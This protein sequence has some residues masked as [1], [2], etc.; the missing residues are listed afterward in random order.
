MFMRPNLK[1]SSQNDEKVVNEPILLWAKTQY[2]KHY[3]NPSSYNNGFYTIFKIKNKI[4]LFLEY[5]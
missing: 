2:R 1:L 5:N 3:C 4:L